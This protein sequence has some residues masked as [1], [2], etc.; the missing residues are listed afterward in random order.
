MLRMLYHLF[1]LPRNILQTNLRVNQCL[2]K[3]LRA[4][5]TL[6]RMLFVPP[7]ALTNSTSDILFSEKVNL[8]Q[9]E[10]LL[11]EVAG[12]LFETHSGWVFPLLVEYWFA[13]AYLNLFGKGFLLHGLLWAL[14][15]YLIWLFF[16]YY[17]LHWGADLLFV[18]VLGLWMDH[19]FVLVLPLFILIISLIF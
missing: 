3:T 2:S 14:L 9:R 10:E 12:Q 18:L 6:E 15:L 13:G 8:P 19:L 7:I 1:E 11:W 16:L 4:I 17:L 5:L